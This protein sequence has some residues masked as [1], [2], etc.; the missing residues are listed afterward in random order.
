MPPGTSAL[1]KAQGYGLF[2]TQANGSPAIDLF[3]LHETV[4]LRNTTL[5]AESMRGW[6]DTGARLSRQGRIHLTV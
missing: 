5:Y 4:R 1:V 6:T 3:V 2:L